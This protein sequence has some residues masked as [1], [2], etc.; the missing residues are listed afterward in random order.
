M[1]RSSASP[2][3][4]SCVPFLFSFFSLPCSKVVKPVKNLPMCL[5]PPS[6]SAPSLLPF[7]PFHPFIHLSPLKDLPPSTT[8]LSILSPSLSHFLPFPSFHF[9]IYSSPNTACVSVSL[10]NKPRFRTCS[11]RGIFARG[12]ASSALRYAWRIA[13]VLSRCV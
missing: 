9:F 11:A 6:S 7:H 12:C 1:P 5:F 8:L 10:P 2:Q 4:F 13:V 3:C